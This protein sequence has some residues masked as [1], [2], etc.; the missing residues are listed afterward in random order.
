MVWSHLPFFG[1]VVTFPR[2]VM[3]SARERAGHDSIHVSNISA[4]TGFRGHCIHRQRSRGAQNSSHLCMSRLF[5]SMIDRDALSTPGP[6]ALW[7][8]LP[9][10]RLWSET[11]GTCKYGY[12]SERPGMSGHGFSSDRSRCPPKNRILRSKRIS[13]ALRAD[14]MPIR[15]NIHE[16]FTFSADTGF[17]LLLYP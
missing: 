11:V 5:R 1:T 16:C 6:D 3:R 15:Q 7:R 13:R 12:C 9:L 2:I 17:C 14:R 4:G 10:G 8:A